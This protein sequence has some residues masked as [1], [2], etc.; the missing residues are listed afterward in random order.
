MHCEFDV[1]QY[2]KKHWVFLTCAWH[3]MNLMNTI[4]Q[5]ISH[6]AKVVLHQE[7]HLLVGILSMWAACQLSSVSLS[8]CCFI[9]MK[10]EDELWENIDSVIYTWQT[11][12]HCICL[13]RSVEAKLAGGKRG[14][15]RA[16]SQTRPD[17]ARP[18][19]T[20]AAWLGVSWG[21]CI[22]TRSFEC[23]VGKV[24]SLFGIVRSVCQFA[25]LLWTTLWW[26]PVKYLEEVSCYSHPSPAI[27]HVC[28]HGWAW[29]VHASCLLLSHSSPPNTERHVSSPSVIAVPGTV[30]KCTRGG[31]CHIQ[32][33]Q[34]PRRCFPPE[35]VAAFASWA[36]AGTNPCS[37][38]VCRVPC[39]SVKPAMFGSTCSSL[40]CCR[41]GTCSPWTA[42]CG[43][44][45]S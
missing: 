4:L 45:L 12:S 19:L 7:F 39:A 33:R 11:G 27:P 34:W 24:A 14:Q 3:T 18:G 43:A 9:K 30:S 2:F 35:R 1:F 36:W 13:G 28:E 23:F 6:W 37:R 16:S 5:S 31:T 8:T 42:D 25:L 41:A 40:P 38:S 10:V 15:R 22:Q 21:G 32:E 29:K 26:G 17:A 20:E 44:S